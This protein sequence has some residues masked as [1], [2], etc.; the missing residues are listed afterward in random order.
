M[1]HAGWMRSAVVGRVAGSPAVRAALLVLAVGAPALAIRLDVLHRS[2]WLSVGTYDD[3]VHFSAAIALLHGRLPYRDVL[4]LQP[5]G[6]LLALSPF[7]AVAD[8]VGD[9]RA[10]ALARIAFCGLG[11]LD[12]ALVTLV[13]RRAG[14]GTVAAIVGGAVLAVFWPA[15]YVSRTLLLEP[16]GTTAILLALLVLQRARTSPRWWFVAGALAG[17]AVGVKIWNL[18]PALVLLLFAHRG[19]LRFLVG[20][21]AAVLA[22]YTPFFAASPDRMWQ[23]VVLAQL[24]RPPSSNGV[25]RRLQVILGANAP[26]GD[27]SPLAGVSGRTLTTLLA[28][29]VV[30]SAVAALVDARTRVLVALLAADVALLMTSPSFF[31][32]YAGFTSAPLALVVGAGIG[33]LLR[34]VVEPVPRIVV[35][36]LVVCLV[37]GIAASSA[38]RRLDLQPP[39]A[40]LRQEVARVDGCVVADDPAVLIVLNRLSR[41]LER[42]CPFEADL[43]GSGYV[44]AIG[45]DDPGGRYEDPRFQ[46]RAIAYLHSGSAYLRIRGAGLQLDERSLALLERDPVLAGRGRWALRTP[47]G[48]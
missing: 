46:R 38:H 6:V 8:V 25:A 44:L 7:A 19:R 36:L 37:A 41:D 39:V 9:A 2:G 43:S 26:S 33:V 28:L 13:L 5:P 10:F 3:G 29:A 15:V 22:V 42:G 17:M 35:A 16:L 21:A 34:G 30:G 48:G 27:G 11:A 31:Q 4:F 32:Q 24:G 47:A 1:H 12:A 18:V 23:Q 14:S 20:A 40:A 45:H